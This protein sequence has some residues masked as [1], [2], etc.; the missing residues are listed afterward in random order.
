MVKERIKKYLPKSLKFLLFDISWDAI[1]TWVGAKI[2]I[3]IPTA[4]FSF[5][6]QNLYFCLDSPFYC[7]TSNYSEILLVIGLILMLLSIIINKKEYEF[8]YRKKKNANGYILKNHFITKKGIKFD[9][10]SYLGAGKKQ[11]DLIIVSCVQV[12]LKNITNKHIVI[13]KAYIISNSNGKKIPIKIKTHN[14]GY[15][16]F[17]HLTQGIPPTPNQWFYTQ[18]LF[19]K[20]G[21]Q[22]EGLV[23]DKFLREFSDFSYI[24]NI[25]GK[26]IIVKTVKPNEA[27]ILLK[28]HFPDPEPTP[29]LTSK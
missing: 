7:V 16:D 13:D 21:D 29:T 24:I 15:V 19:Y 11:D 4:A 20:I 14:K 25:E 1:K 3:I 28:T 27:K 10:T 8:F 18:A 9:F 2:T 26:D 23:Y 12:R 22:T 17:E 5:I 6:G